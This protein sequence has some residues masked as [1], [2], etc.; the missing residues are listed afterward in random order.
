[1]KPFVLLSSRPEDEAA[2][3]EYEGFRHAC[4]LDA[5]DL[6][7]I[8]VAEAPMPSLDLDAISGVI[9]G[10]GPFNAS[11]PV[12]EKSS[13]QLRVEEEFHQLLDRIYERDFPFMGA[14]YGI[15]TLGV[16]QG[17][18]I[19]RTY[20]E[21]VGSAPISLTDE[22]MADP[23]LADL[24]RTFTAFVGHKEACSQLPASAVLLASS[25]ACPVQMFRVRT[26]LY[27][28]QFH[29]ELT[30]ASIIK[31]I[32]IYRHAGYFPPE[33]MDALIQQVGQVQVDAPP[34]ILANFVGHYAR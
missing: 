3:D 30:R 12:E 21:P 18:V 14:C 15:G 19:D 9:V 29:P 24:P 5:S 34:K 25:P 13:V 2:A 31:R 8:R 4:G 11:D 33:D 23:V 1:M 6:K 20:G 10:G 32:R 17:G 7:M 28:T 16:H 22:G 26:N 27:A